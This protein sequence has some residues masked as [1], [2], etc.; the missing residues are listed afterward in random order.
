MESAH[1]MAIPSTATMMFGHVE[2]IKERIEHLE[3]LRTL[4][5]KTQGFTAFITW[6]FQ[7]GNTQ[8]QG[9]SGIKTAITG[10]E[11]LKTL[12]ISRIFLDN[13]RNLQSSWVTQGP[14]VGQLSLY[15][16]ANDMGSTMMEEN[17]VAA[18]G[19]VYCMDEKEINRL[20][21][22]SGFIP[23]RRNMKYDYL[24]Q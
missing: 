23:R 22:D 21:T 17:V 19:T 13:F 12:A 1:G 10:F 2:T 14:K 18:A 24:P 3:R 6:G 7:P 5:D 11:Y 8:L 20:I 4:Q 16:G 15:Y 9:D